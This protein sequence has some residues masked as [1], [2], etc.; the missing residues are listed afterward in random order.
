[1]RETYY[2]LINPILYYRIVGP[3]FHRELLGFSR[4]CNSFE[5]MYLVGSEWKSDNFEKAK[6]DD[7]YLS[8]ISLRRFGVTKPMKIN[9]EACKYNW[10]KLVDSIQEEGVKTPLIAEVTD[11]GGFIVIEGKH[12]FGAA[13]LI[14]PFNLDFKL[15]C[16]LIA[17]DIFYTAKMWKQRHP[18]AFT[19]E[20]YSTYESK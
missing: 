11:E 9:P 4:P 13:S 6:L 14:K 16:L 3:G 18:N 20:G 8:Y 10:T 12:R 1:M 2:K 15:P 7:H 19:S 5:L 17:R